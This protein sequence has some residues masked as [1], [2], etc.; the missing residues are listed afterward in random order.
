MLRDSIEIA[1][2][3]FPLGSGFATYGSFMAKEHYSPLYTTLG[4]NMIYGMSENIPYFLSDS[5]WPIIIAQFGFV[6][7]ICFSLIVLC[8]VKIAFRFRENTYEF[9]ALLSIMLYMIISSTSESSFFNPFVTMFFIIFGLIV[10]QNLSQ[11]RKA[12]SLFRHM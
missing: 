3:F 8:F 2:Q 12:K 10:N 6:G 11:G 4:Y 1:K 9:L 5:F 7:I